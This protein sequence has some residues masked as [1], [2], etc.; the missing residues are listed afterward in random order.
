MT[1]ASQT[2]NSGITHEQMARI[3]AS[4]NEAKEVIRAMAQQAILE[5]VMPSASSD[6]KGPRL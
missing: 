2:S 3:E 1:N 6:G 5:N 4:V